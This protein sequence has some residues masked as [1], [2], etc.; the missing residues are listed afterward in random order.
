[1]LPEAHEEL[2]TKVQ[3]PL[4][5]Q[6]VPLHGLGLQEPPDVQLLPEEQEELL[7][8][9]H[10]PLLPQQQP[11]QGFGLHDPPDVQVP[12]QFQE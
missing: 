8:K 3:A 9:V 2:L 10:E 11:A 4:L 7:T 6:Q 1:V 5:L 12:L